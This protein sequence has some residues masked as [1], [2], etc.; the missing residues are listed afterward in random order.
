MAKATA[1]CSKCRYAARGCGRCV[2]GFVPA[3]E[4]RAR[5]AAEKRP[6][7]AAAPLAPLDANAPAAKR[8]RGRPPGP[9][10]SKSTTKRLSG[11]G[12]KTPKTPATKPAGAT[13]VSPPT[14]AKKAPPR[15]LR[16]AP[17]PG[18]RA[19]EVPR[20]PPP[21]F[22][23]ASAAQQRLPASRGASHHHHHHTADDVKT[24]APAAA[25]SSAA[26]RNPHDPRASSPADSDSL[27]AHLPGVPPARRDPASLVPGRPVPAPNDTAVRRERTTQLCGGARL[28][29][30][31][32]SDAE[33]AE[34]VLGGVGRYSRL[35]DRDLLGV[36]FPPELREALAAAAEGRGASHRRS[37]F[38]A[39]SH[40][41]G[42]GGVGN[43]TAPGFVAAPPPAASASPFVKHASG[44]GR[45]LFEA[46]C[47]LGGPSEA[48]AWASSG[49]GGPGGPIIRGAPARESTTQPFVGSVG[50]RAGDPAR[51]AAA[52]AEWKARTERRER[53]AREEAEARELARSF[54]NVTG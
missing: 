44:S 11:Q 50:P 24:A 7:P 34:R 43:T 54:V 22:D 31:G 19:P 36:P 25:A 49:A 3:S 35:G 46:A 6:A 41:R 27:P 53:E 26:P 1:G 38:G 33:L 40:A 5:Q 37:D 45:T 20:P 17:H 23:D 29:G 13:R 21:G 18:T 30:G 32:L 28:G 9:S 39:P 14:S 10:S 2:K 4:A 52:L 8:P 16:D 42:G 15:E 12:A 48:P 51:G 47:E